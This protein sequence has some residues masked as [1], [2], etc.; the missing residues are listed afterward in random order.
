MARTILL[1]ISA[2]NV[3]ITWILIS[4]GAT[5]RLYGAGLACPDWPLCYGSLAPPA[6]LSIILEVG[7]RY[8]ASFLGLL[9]MLAF[10][11][12]YNSKLK[13]HCR[14]AGWLFFL[15]VL[16]G[17]VGGLTVLLKLNFSTVV[18]HLLLG[19][20][21][22][23]GLVYFLYELV[24]LP[25]VSIKILLQKPPKIYR[26][27]WLLCGL[28]FFMLF[29][30]GLNSSNYAGYACSAF[31]FCSPTSSFSFYWDRVSGNFFWNS[32]IGYDFMV[33]LLEFIHLSHRLIVVIGSIILIYFAVKKLLSGNNFFFYFGMMLILF[34]LAEIVVGVINALYFIPIPISILHTTLAS[35]I[36]G[37]L[38][39]LLIRA[40]YSGL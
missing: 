20:L 8:L 29:S 26:Q 34:I 7:H 37:I 16:Q 40:R 15:V 13:N 10:F 25:T 9:I 5:V 38:A 33:T 11:L 30:G 3:F 19:N 12:C 17:V 14:L 2:L 36:T 24:F 4:F 35:S 18:L 22:F 39:L 31:P 28:Y 27:L 21:L 32:W 23:F 1:F 6:N